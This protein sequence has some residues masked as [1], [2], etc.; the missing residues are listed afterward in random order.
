[1]PPHLV[2]WLGFVINFIRYTIGYIIKEATISTCFDITYQAT[3]NYTNSDLNLTTRQ[4]KWE[5]QLG[6][7]LQV[8]RKGIIV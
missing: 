6:I 5:N 7:I 2:N 1:M 3:N 8:V 4:N